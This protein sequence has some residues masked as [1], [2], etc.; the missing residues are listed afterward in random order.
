MKRAKTLAASPLHIHPHLDHTSV[1]DRAL[2]SEQ[3]VYL[4]G[5]QQ[6]TPVF[7]DTSGSTLVVTAGSSVGMDGMYNMYNMYFDIS[8][9]SIPGA[10]S[11]TVSL[12]TLNPDE[13]YTVVYTDNTSARVYLHW[14]GP[15]GENYP[16]TVTASDICRT[17]GTSTLQPCFL[18][19][20]IVQMADGSQK[21]IETVV[22]GD[23]LLGA[24]GEV[25]PVLALH[26]PLLGSAHM[27]RINGEHST[28]AHHPHVSADRKFYCS[29]PSVVETTTYGHE[30]DVIDGSGNTVKRMLY[31]LKKGR[32]Q[33]MQVGVI[34]KTVEGSR[35]VVTLET[36]D[37]PPETQLYNLVMGGSHTYHVDGYAVTGW[38]REDDW[39]YDTWTAMQPA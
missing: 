11:Y 19:G 6:N 17:R 33:H 16:V 15:I 28:T 20:A 32:V 24:F 10:S 4:Y 12:I 35:P 7:C 18:E 1:L 34:L 25:N 2:F 36:Y 9:N 13:F 37:L 27:N 30:H 21:T 39:D 29:E 23:L 3:A 22:V 26:R 31:G 14:V 5:V 8:W 38:P